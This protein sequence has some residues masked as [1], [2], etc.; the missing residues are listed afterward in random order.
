MPV[1]FCVQEPSF[2]TPGKKQLH[3]IKKQ[4]N[5][6][7]NIKKKQENTIIESPNE[8]LPDRSVFYTMQPH[9]ET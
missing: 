6:L 5:N 3:A 8:R 1:A 2:F 9:L 4:N 7:N